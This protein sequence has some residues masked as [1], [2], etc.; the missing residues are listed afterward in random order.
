MLLYLQEEQ[1]N[2]AHGKDVGSVA[3]ISAMCTRLTISRM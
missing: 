1:K 3:V 2:M